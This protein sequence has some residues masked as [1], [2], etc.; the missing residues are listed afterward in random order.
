M[1]ISIGG[2]KFN[3]TP[4]HEFLFWEWVNSGRWEGY[5]FKTFKQFLRKDKSYIDV[6]CW[7]GPTVFYGCQLARHCYAIEPDPVAFGIFKENLGLNNFSNISAYHV[8]IADGTGVLNVGRGP[9]TG[10]GESGFGEFGNSCTTWVSA[11]SAISVPC[12][13]LEDFFTANNIVDCNFI[14]IDTEGAEVLIL[15]KARDFLK[16]FKPTIQIGF[17]SQLFENKGLYFN[18]IEEA[19]SPTYPNFYLITGEKKEWSFLPEL[20]GWDDIVVNSAN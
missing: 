4:H 13:T 7:I 17:H 10:V 16:S 14:K 1:E 12:L 8:A 3:V 19:L 18:T 9:K 2:L 15:P 20:T 6:G 11:V 5:T